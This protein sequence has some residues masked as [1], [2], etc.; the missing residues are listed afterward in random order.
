MT[1]V[2]FLGLIV[3]E[4]CVEMDP[5]KV[6]GVS[7]WPVPK[8]KKDVQSF[9]GFTNFYRRFIKDYAKIARPLHNLTGKKDW[10]WGTSQQESFEKLK[11]ALT[12]APV[13]RMP[14]DEGKYHIEVDSSDF[15]TGAVL[16]Q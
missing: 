16:S 13:L 2:E 9:L 4:N 10:E 1:R 7:K 5:I 6:E 12:S 15:A 11:Q 3:S 14:T 8:K